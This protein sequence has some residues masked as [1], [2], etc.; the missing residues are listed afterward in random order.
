MEMTISAEEALNPNMLLSVASTRA[1]CCLG[2]QQNEFTAILSVADSSAD[3][4]DS[5]EDEFLATNL[6][7]IRLCRALDGYYLGDLQA[8]RDWLNNHITELDCTPLELMKQSK[9]LAT[10]VEFMEK[11]ALN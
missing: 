3:D 4:S 1:A 11:K 2:L 7:F 8:E 9:G 5:S 10:L 6:L